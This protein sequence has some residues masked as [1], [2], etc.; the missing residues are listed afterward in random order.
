MIAC[1]AMRLSVV[2][3][4]MRGRV[5]KTIIHQSDISAWIRCPAEFNFA[6][7]GL[8]NATNSASAFGSVM[9][10]SLQVFERVRIAE[11]FDS[12]VK[13]AIETF[14]YYWNP[15]NIEAI[16]D[17]VPPNGW[18]PRQGYSELLNR[19]IDSI[20]K[21]A[22]L[23]KFDD[24][25]MLAT[26]FSFIVNIPGTWDEQLQEPHKLAGSIDQLTAGHYNRKLFLHIRDLKTGKEYVHL[27]QNMQFTAYSLATLDPE[28]WT[29]GE[30]EDG[31]GYDRGM[32]LYERFSGAG[33]RGT[34][35]NLK[36]FKMQDAGWRG[37]KDYTRFAIA[38]NQ[39]AL[40]IQADI[41]PLSL[42]GEACTYCAFRDI[43][44]GV[45]IGTADHGKPGNLDG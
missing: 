40:S 15:V 11:N 28:F 35:I 10:N 7:Q 37:P 25:E 27:R 32:E 6:R 42:S 3:F 39:I 21:Y 8:P 41:F 36:T 20:R 23:V 26:E 9:H 30:M 14:R 13:K 38:C 5:S 4:F 43:C 2:S 17:P 33:R 16:C 24:I 29:G 31:F 44:G 45:G 22:D 19:G 12:A 34:W 1:C 18:L